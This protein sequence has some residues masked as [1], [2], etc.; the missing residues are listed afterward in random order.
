MTWKYDQST[1]EI[2]SPDGTFFATGYSGKGKKNREGRN[3]PDMETVVAVGP[4]PRGK[5]LMN[6]VYDS[7]Q[8]GPFAIVLLPQGHDAHGRE[9]FRIHGNNKA[10]DASHGCI[11]LSPQSLREHIWNSGDHDLEVV[12]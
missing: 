2:T 10:D 4:I 9:A 1:G 7:K 12:E 3:N 8:V 6:G 11:I 5:W